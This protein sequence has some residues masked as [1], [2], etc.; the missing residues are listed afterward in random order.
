MLEPILIN[1]YGDTAQ[2]E[3][4]PAWRSE[5]QRYLAARCDAHVQE[6]LLRIV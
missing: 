5:Y 3:F 2:Q 6:W 4:L 1:V